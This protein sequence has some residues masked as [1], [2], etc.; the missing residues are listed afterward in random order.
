MKDD[1]PVGAVLALDPGLRAG[2]AVRSKDLAHCPTVYEGSVFDRNCFSWITTELSR[3][4]TPE[5]RTAFVVEN[6]A[7]GGLHIAKSLGKCIGVVEGLLLDIGALRSDED[8]IEV[9][10]VTW[11]PADVVEEAA[12]QGGGRIKLKKAAQQFVRCK[13]GLDLGPDGAEAVLINDWATENLS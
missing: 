5:H 7:F 8:I 13:Y 11:R 10:A 3:W 2:V 9:A 4:C 12:R 1:R 6:N